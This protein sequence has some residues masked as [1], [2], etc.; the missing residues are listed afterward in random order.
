MKTTLPGLS[1]GIVPNKSPMLTAQLSDFNI[2]Y[3]RIL[4]ACKGRLPVIGK[5]LRQARM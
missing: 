2:D 3:S 1:D 5:S 4:Q